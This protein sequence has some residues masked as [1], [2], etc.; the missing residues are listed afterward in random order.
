MSNDLTTALQY[1]QNGCLEEAAR[2]YQTILSVDP[3]HA[4]AL[5]LLG[6][7]AHQQRDQARTVELIGRAIAINPGVAAYHANLAEALRAG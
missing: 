4:D 3:H 6:V 7:V 5:H 2:L 1:H